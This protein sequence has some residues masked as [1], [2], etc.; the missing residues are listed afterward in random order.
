MNTLPCSCNAGS[1]QGSPCLNCGSEPIDDAEL[2]VAGICL[3]AVLV[4][5]SVVILHW[6]VRGKPP[7]R[8]PHAGI[9]YGTHYDALQGR[10]E[11]V[12]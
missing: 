10:C 4:I 8:D 11:E 7:C 9:T 1:F 6:F 2:A 5:I 3:G 12:R